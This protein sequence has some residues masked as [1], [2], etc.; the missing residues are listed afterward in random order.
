LARLSVLLAVLSASGAAAQTSEYVGSHACRSCHAK[1]FESQSKTGHA[2]ALARAAEGSPGQWAFGAGLKAIT[3]VSQSGEDAYVEHGMSYY[4]AT[5][6][7]ALTPGHMDSKD[8]RYR[9]FDPDATAL[10]CFRC[11]STG[12]L[13]VDTSTRGIRPSEP[14]IHCE[15]CHGPGGEHVKSGGAAALVNPRR[16]SAIELNNFCGTCH[17]K[18]PEGD[19]TDKWRTRHQPSYL[20]QA[21]CFRKSGGTLTCLTCHDPHGPLAETA[22]SYTQFCVNCHK[23]PRHQTAVGKR[24]CSDCHMPQVVINAELRF[25]NHWIGIYSKGSDLV[26]VR[27]TVRSLPPLPGSGAILTAPADSISLRPLFEQALADHEKQHGS[28]DPAVARAASDLGLFLHQTGDAARSETLLRRALD[29][30][31][32]NE[33]SH[34]A[35]DQ[36]NL[37]RVL[38]GQGKRQEAFDLFERAATGVDPQI[39]SQS[40][41]SLAILD[42]AH[43]E[44]YYRSAF[45]AQK[46]VSAGDQKE[47]AVLLN[48]LAMAIEQ[49]KDYAAAEALFRQA[50]AIQERLLGVENPATASTLSNLGSLLESA[51]KLLEAEQMERR[52]V[53]IFE[54]TL[55]PY[56][57]ELAT[58]CTN[59]ADVLWA[60][61]DWTSAA[62]LYKRAIAIDESVYGPENPEVGGD[63]VNYATLLRESGQGTAAVRA[64]RR[65]LA[66]YEA[67]FGPNSP[68]ALQIR[69]DLGPP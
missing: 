47:T 7:M 53:R 63:L 16:L 39:A 20:N 62:N 15:A 35:A 68:Q 2:R 9:T 10:K 55:G 34:V 38:V 12:P 17:R 64:L 66:I 42:P 61:R 49:R 21:A 1:Q 3:W 19:W 31:L 18:T 29:I 28:G 26:P 41:A 4:S 25:T 58:S 69:R 46:K 44:Q 48:D 24:A 65:A 14:G 54:R 23:A 52:A 27:S 43:A 50:L 13:S 51:G 67:A 57:A 30:D 59:L 60:K 5:K 56:S 11:H 6:S 40:F 8:V 36:Q 22:A 32:N 45:E 37:A 33:D